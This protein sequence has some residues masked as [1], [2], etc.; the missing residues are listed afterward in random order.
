MCVFFLV[1]HVSDLISDLLV[2]KFIMGD[3][4][5]VTDIAARSAGLFP[6]MP[7]WPG[8]HSNVIVLLLNLCLRYCL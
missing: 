3:G 7:V 6:C 4:C 8:I 1:I 2:L 5:V